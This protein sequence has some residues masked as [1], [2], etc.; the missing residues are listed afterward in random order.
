[1]SLHFRPSPQFCLS[2]SM[3]VGIVLLSIVVLY[4]YGQD[5]ITS[6][7]RCQEEIPVFATFFSVTHF[8]V[9]LFGRFMYNV[10]RR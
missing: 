8:R 4:R 1:M 2:W 7:T 10:A 6:E 3:N 5:R 9:A